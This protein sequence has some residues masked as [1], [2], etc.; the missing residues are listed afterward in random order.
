[1]DRRRLE[2]MFYLTQEIKK[3]QERI[4]VLE[5]IAQGT[6]SVLT[7]LPRPSEKRD[8]IGEVTVKLL[9]IR[10]RWEMDRRKYVE[11]LDQLQRY[12]SGIGDSE[13]RQICLL[14]FG[15]GYSWRK[16]AWEMGGY[17]TE[18]S[19]K[20]LCYRFLDKRRPECPGDM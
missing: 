8:R 1:M 5:S 12:L 13:I 17:A 19:V 3:H 16:V 9:D 4:E 10:S 11:E 7:G 2:Q 18:D 14:R 6:T 20:K 15:C